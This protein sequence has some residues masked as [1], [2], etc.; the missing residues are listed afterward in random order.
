V[1][2][3][4]RLHNVCFA[5]A[6]YG[7]SHDE[8]RKD[9]D[10][11]LKPALDYGLHIFDRQHGIV[12][13]SADQYR[14]PEIYQS[15]IKGHLSYDHLVKAYKRYKVFLNVNSVKTSPTM[16]SRRIFEL[17]ACG[18]PV[19]SAY[20]RGIEN[21]LGSDIVAFSGSEEE[22]KKH[23]DRLLGNDSEWARAS[24]RGIRAVFDR[25]TYAERWQTLCQKVDPGLASTTPKTVTVIA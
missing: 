3:T 4:E 5:G 8:R 2:E 14:F 21:L 18:T 20:A 16:F 17:L 9:M 22:T 13:P 23:L 7:L 24:A 19:I 15:A 1:L 6:Y 11:V 25:H 10:I 12:G